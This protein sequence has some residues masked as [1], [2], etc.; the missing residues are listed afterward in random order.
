[1]QQGQSRQLGLKA[2]EGEQDAKVAFIYQP[3]VIRENK[4]WSF[5][6]AQVNFVMY[7]EKF[8]AET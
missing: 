3:A 7:P 4:V 1:M 5:K 6:K 2:A 8:A